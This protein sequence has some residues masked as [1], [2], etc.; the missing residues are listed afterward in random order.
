MN[1]FSTCR[2]IG[3]SSDFVVVHREVRIGALLHIATIG[4]SLRDELVSRECYS[5]CGA[6]NDRDV[7]SDVQS[8]SVIC[9]CKSDLSS[10]K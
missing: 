4:N 8:G 7:G 2:C 9:E 3:E 1:S 5:R 10:L 6:I